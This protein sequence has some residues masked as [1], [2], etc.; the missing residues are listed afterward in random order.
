MEGSGSVQIIT[1][2]DPWSPKT[3]DPGSPKY[4][5]SGS[6][7]LQY[8]V[9]LPGREEVWRAPPVWACEQAWQPAHTHTSYLH[10]RTIIKQKTLSRTRN[11]SK[12]N[13]MLTTFVPQSIDWFTYNVKRTRLS[14]RRMICSFSVFLCVSPVKLTDGWEVGKGWARSQ[15]I[16]RRESLILC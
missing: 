16:R 4:C 1:D 5:G 3:C 12:C 7:T 10:T 15:I 9:H 6:G 11:F 2:P 14:R 8:T 13:N